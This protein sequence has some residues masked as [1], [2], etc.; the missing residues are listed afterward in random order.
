MKASLVLPVLALSVVIALSVGIAAGA[1]GTGRAVKV[2]QMS[3]AVHRHH[4]H[5]HHGG[6]HGGAGSKRN[7]SGDLSTAWL[8]GALGIAVLIGAAGGEILVNLV[9][10]E[11]GNV[12]AR[13]SESG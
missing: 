4:V 8:L 12:T 3:L 2:P 13:P 9:G 7:K 6:A 10:R 5:H 1:V 11:A